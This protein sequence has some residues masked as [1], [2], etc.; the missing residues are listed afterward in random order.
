MSKESGGHRKARPPLMVEAAARRAF[1]QRLVAPSAGRVDLLFDS[2][3]DEVQRDG[4]PRVLLLSAATFDAMLTVELSAQGAVVSGALMPQQVTRIG[5]RRP[6]RATIALR[7]D[8]R[9]VI[10]DTLVPCGP[11]CFVVETVDGAT[12]ESE[13]LTL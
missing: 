4:L 8:A 12:W 7:I 5:L 3:R 9:G 13:W 10:A 1:Q 6:M 11:A 2:T